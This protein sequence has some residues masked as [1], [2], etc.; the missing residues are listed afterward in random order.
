[1]TREVVQRIASVDVRI[2]KRGIQQERTVVARE[3]IGV[4]SQALQDRTA[5][6]MDLGSFGSSARIRS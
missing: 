6:V 3:R 1:M 5:I 2:G 4:T